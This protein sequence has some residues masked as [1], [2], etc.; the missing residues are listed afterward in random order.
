MPDSALPHDAATNP[1][2]V[3]GHDSER[4][5]E[6]YELTRSKLIMFFAQRRV[7]DPEELA[8][9]T[10][11]A[12]MRQLSK[13]V[14]VDNP[15]AYCFGVAK[16]IFRQYCRAERKRREG[17]EELKHRTEVG[18]S[19]EDDE[20]DLLRERQLECVNE[21]VEELPEKQRQLLFE[22]EK[23]PEGRDK[24]EHRTRLA[25]MLNISKGA[26]SSKIFQ[27]RSR[28]KL[29]LADRLLSEDKSPAQRR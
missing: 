12:F 10:L 21:C 3:W 20:M 9:A 16:N 11:L 24:I 27:I 23:F 22:Y 15:E 2:A 19:R 6:R 18:R 4:A 7:P 8:G 26:L 28:L 29:R 5:A 17:A 13:G 1:W 25:K 14:V